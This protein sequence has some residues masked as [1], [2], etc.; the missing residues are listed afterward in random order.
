MYALHWKKHGKI[1][2]YPYDYMADFGGSPIDYLFTNWF[3]KQGY[4]RAGLQSKF[5]PKDS[6]EKKVK[7]FLSRIF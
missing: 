1:D 6:K 3:A 7:R 4:F 5:E 2:I